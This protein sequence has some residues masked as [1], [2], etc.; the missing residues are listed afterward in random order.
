MRS[1]RW[2]THSTMGFG[3]AG[4]VRALGRHACGVVRRGLCLPGEPATEQRRKAPSDFLLTVPVRTHELHPLRE[5]SQLW[6]CPPVA[7]RDV[8]S[9]TWHTPH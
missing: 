6:A 3:V 8:T 2:P 9:Q 1:R 7:F 5:L 4:D